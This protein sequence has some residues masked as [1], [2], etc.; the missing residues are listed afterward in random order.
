MVRQRSDHPLRHA[1]RL[2]GQI[3]RRCGERGILCDIGAGHEPTGLSESWPG[4]WLTVDLVPAPGLDVIADGQ[5]LPFREKSL[6]GVLLVQVLEHVADPRR[7]LQECARVLQPGG[8]VALTAPQYHITH[9]HPRD[10]FR[11]TRDGLAHLCGEAGLRVVEAR[12]IGGPVLVVFHAIELN[13]PAKLRVLFVAG[14]YR[15]ADWLDGRLGDH[16]NAAGAADALGWAV[17]AGR[18]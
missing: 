3:A 11:Y 16:G 18:E 13:L 15:F 2:L 6:D 8:L 12:A 1:R 10:F 14:F 9:G 17:L 4:R 7:L 5:A